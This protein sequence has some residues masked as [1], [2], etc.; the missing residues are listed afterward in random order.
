V[1][2][3]D[4]SIDT[5]IAEQV[6]YYRERASEYD[7][8]SR[9]DGDPFAAIHDEI[10]ADLSSLG[11]VDR[12]IELG[13]GTGAFTGAVGAISKEAIA[14]DASPEMLAINRSRVDAPNVERIVG[15]VF[16]WAPDEL[17]DVVIFAFLLSHIPDGRF[18]G[19]WAA[20]ERMLR[21]GGVAFV[22]D[23]ARHELWRE[24]PAADPAGQLVYRTL[25]D[26]RRFRIVK[27]LWDPDELTRR[28][29]R[30]GW[31]AVL[32]RQGPFLWGTVTRR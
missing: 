27:V 29:S 10:V 16:T 6:R 14:L 5:L 8:T 23:E 31:D 11:P 22:A 32:K 3:S 17:A 2:A 19:F 25:N 9:P 4:E 20:V 26:G 28:L 24:E 13:A 18:E 12:A 30:L 15:D 21:P 1:A 7:Q